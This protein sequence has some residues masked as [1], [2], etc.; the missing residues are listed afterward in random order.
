[1]IEYK[2]I[3]KCYKSSIAEKE[4]TE[5]FA[6]IIITISIEKI[7]REIHKCIGKLIF[8]LMKDIICMRMYYQSRKIFSLVLPEMIDLS[9][10][11]NWINKPLTNIHHQIMHIRILNF[12]T[13]SIL[14][15]HPSMLTRKIRLVI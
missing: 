4:T 2:E 12:T 5:L 1:M 11:A 7:N 3:L 6:M 15:L 14:M 8:W 10:G 9:E 13:L